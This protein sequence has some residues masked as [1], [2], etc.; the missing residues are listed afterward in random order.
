MSEMLDFLTPLLENAEIRLSPAQLTQLDGH[1]RLLLEWNEV[2]NLTGI[3]DPADAANLHY[4][5][6]L[7][8][9]PEIVSRSTKVS[10]WLDIGSGGGFPG[11]PLAIALPDL[12]FVLVERRER[13]AGFL[14]EVVQQLKLDDRVTVIGDT[15]DQHTAPRLLGDVSRETFG[16][17]ARALE[18]MPEQLPKLLR[19]PRLETAL[20]WLGSN[21]AAEAVKQ[22]GATWNTTLRTLPSGPNRPL[23]ILDRK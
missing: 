15:L 20:L 21:A 1:F 8:A 14:F 6:A 3:T 18:K 4:L 17:C 16:I 7:A 23:L 19:I 9:I 5:D 10:T 11:I 12:K 2:T 13:K 22:H